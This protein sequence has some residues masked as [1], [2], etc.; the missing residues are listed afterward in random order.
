MGNFTYDDMFDAWKNIYVGIRYMRWIYK[1]LAEK[2]GISKDVAIPFTVMAY[3]WG[4]GN[5]TRWLNETQ[6]SNNVIDEIVPFE[7]KNH[8]LDYIWWKNHWSNV[9]NEGERRN[10][11]LRNGL[12]DSRNTV[13]TDM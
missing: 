8:L 5:F 7:T 4:I 3:N 2:K 6:A 12:C 13:S 11:K 10:E 9:F 1:Y